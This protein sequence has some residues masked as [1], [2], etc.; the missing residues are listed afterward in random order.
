MNKPF[1]IF[2]KSAGYIWSISPVGVLV[3]LGLIVLQGAIPGLLV[4]YTKSIVDFLIA[5]AA[6]RSGAMTRFI[7]WWITLVFLRA[8]MGS[9]LMLVQGNL[10]EKIV[11]RANVDVMRKAAS[12]TDLRPYEDP[13][14]YDTMNVLWQGS[15]S[16]PVNFLLNTSI[17]IRNL[18]AVTSVLVVLG[19]IG[20]YVPALVLFAI[21]PQAYSTWK[22]YRES[23]TAVLE[24][25]PENCKIID[26]SRVLLSNQYAKDHLLF[27]LGGFIIG[28]YRELYGAIH[29]QKG[30]LRRRNI[31]RSVPSSVIYVGVIGFVLMRLVNGIGTGAIAV[32]SVVAFLQSYV[33]L[34]SSLYELIE[35]IGYMDGI[36]LYFNNSIMYRLPTPVECGRCGT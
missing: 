26:T 10:A 6:E 8:A 29:E 32:S 27:G 1:A 33:S 31:A 15:G 36:L 2:W 3:Y 12:F 18:V 16:R 21:V 22:M 34:Q 13:A 23:W 17:T 30:A 25:T 9:F 14:F 24:K 35:N 19:T 28:K 4:F 20:W 5:G 7:V 11:E